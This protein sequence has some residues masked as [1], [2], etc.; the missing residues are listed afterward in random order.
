MK[1]EKK[2]RE[3]AAAENRS[4]RHDFFILETVEAGIELKGSE[5]KS[6]R[7]GGVSLKEG[8][9]HVDRGEVFLEG[10][11]I[12]PYEYAS[13]PL[14]PLRTRRL[15]L[16]RREIHRLGADLKE[17][18]L[19]LVPLRVYFKKGKAKVE[20]GLAKGKK[21]HDKREAIKAREVRR[22]LERVKPR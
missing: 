2:P 9:A 13:A 11:H 8:Y 6:I 17:R 1:A 4:A 20:L 18:R 22:E 7:A 19:T 15:L 5:V 16:H 14:N 21:A 10:V 3:R 12:A